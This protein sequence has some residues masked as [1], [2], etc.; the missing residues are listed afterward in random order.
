MFAPE[1]KLPGGEWDFAGIDLIFREAGGID[2]DLWHSKP[3]FLTEL[4]R[5]DEDDQRSAHHD[6][7]YDMSCI[8]YLSYYSA[9]ALHADVWPD[10]PFDD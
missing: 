5:Y 4:V 2:T 8:S 9:E 7:R 1:G 6:D 10:V 3:I